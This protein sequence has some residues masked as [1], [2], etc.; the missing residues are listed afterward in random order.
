MQVTCN[1]LDA[2]ITCFC[3]TANGLADEE[4]R[5][6][7]KKAKKA[8]AKAKGSQADA[9]KGKL[10]NTIAYFELK[11]AFSYACGPSENV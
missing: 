5:K 2:H 1:M 8:E 3:Y 4:A 6:A 9:K 10:Y 7:A 11:T